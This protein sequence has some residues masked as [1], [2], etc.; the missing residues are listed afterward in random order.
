MRIVTSTIFTMAM[1]VL[2][3]Q[4]ALRIRPLSDV[5]IEEGAA[6]VAHRVDDQVRVW[7]PYVCI[8]NLIWLICKKFQ[9]VKQLSVGF[10]LLSY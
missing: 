8:D 10:S 7:H 3:S 4:V 5:E 1:S 9:L 6:I 2:V